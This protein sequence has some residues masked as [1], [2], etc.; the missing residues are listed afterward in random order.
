MH[1][2]ATLSDAR[3]SLSRT[4][5]ANVGELERA[6][7]ALAGVAM[8]GY[9]WKRGSTSLALMS[10]GLML[11]GVTGYCP[12]YAALDVDHT[13]GSARAERPK[14]VLEAEST[15]GRAAARIEGV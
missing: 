4:L 11:R 9:A 1:Q 13:A 2:T 12:A 14:Q 10:T 7:S 8:L 6:M 5:P 3:Q 15:N